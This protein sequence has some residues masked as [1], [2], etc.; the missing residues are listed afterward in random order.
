MTDPG[1]PRAASWTC[2]AVAVSPVVVMNPATVPD[3]VSTA[4]IP[5]PTAVDAVAGV[6][7]APESDASLTVPVRSSCPRIS[8]AGLAAVCALK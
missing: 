7:C 4:R 1:V 3:V 5:A 8:P 2:A 6:S